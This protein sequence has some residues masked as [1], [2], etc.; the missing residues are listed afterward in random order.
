MQFKA[1]L[2]VLLALWPEA[3][4]IPLMLACWLQVLHG[5]DFQVSSLVK[6]NQHLNLKF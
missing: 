6:L 4:K 1:R 3:F 2:I 5:E